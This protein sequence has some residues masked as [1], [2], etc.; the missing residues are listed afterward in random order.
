MQVERLGKKSYILTING[1]F[2]QFTKIY[3]L[4]H[5]S[6]VIEKLKAF[7]LEIENQFNC[8]IKEIRS[9]RGEEFENKKVDR[10]LRSKGIKD[11]INVPHNLE[12][13][14]VSERENG[15]VVEP[16]QSIPE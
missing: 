16:G 3:F 4:Q 11:T 8:K 12:Q 2:S 6:K 9:D 5:Q 10:F 7:C 15:M 14:G 13:I 1:D